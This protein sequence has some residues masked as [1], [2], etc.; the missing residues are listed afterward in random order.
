MEKRNYLN[1]KERLYVLIL[2]I[3][4]LYFLSG[5]FIGGWL[6]GGGGKDLWLI[7]STG[8]LAF[9][10]FSAPFF[11]KPSDSLATSLS[12]ILLLWSLDLSS[13]N[14]FSLQ[15]NIFRWF[16]IGVNLIIL[17]SSSIAII[18]K[19]R[20]NERS[21]LNKTCYLLSTNLGKGE[22]IFTSP[23][24][25]SILGFHQNKLID[26]LILGFIWILLV[27]IKPVELFFKIK[28][29]VREI[30][31]DST[32]IVGKIQRIDSPNIIRASIDSIDNWNVEDVNIAMLTDAKNV[33]VIPLF[34]Q[35]IDQ[36]IIGTGLCLE[37][38]TEL[39]NKLNKFC[40]YNSNR[41][42]NRSKLIRD[43][44]NIEIEAELIG[45]IVENSNISHI[46]FEISC[47]KNLKEG[48]I[49]FCKQDGENI[50]YQILDVYTTEEKFSSNPRGT[51]II[52]ATQLGEIDSEKGF[53]KY[54]WVPNMNTPVFLTSEDIKDSKENE[55]ELILGK[56]PNSNIDVVAD[57]DY[58]LEY[59]TAILGV[60][61]TG[62]TEMAFDIIKY[63]L[64]NGKKIF[65][66]DFTGDYKARLEEYNPVELSLGEE[67]SKKIEELI[68]KIE[69]GK[70]G[71]EDEKK[72]FKEFID[73]ITP[74]IKKKV[75]NF[76]EDDG[77]GLGIFELPN[78]A[79]SRAMLRATELYLSEIF[80]WARRNRKAREILVVL[81][82][83]HT[84]IPET[85]VFGYDKADTNLIINKI[86]QI[87][88]QG[89][90]YGVGLL[91]ISQ[92]T[93]LV[94]K[95]ILSQCNTYL[96]FSLVDQT[97]LKY[98]SS[99]YSSEH[100]DLIPNL[101]FLHT[102]VYGKGIKSE[103]SI[104]VEIPFDEQKQKETE[105]LND[106]IDNKDDSQVN[107]NEEVAATEEELDV[108]F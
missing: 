105:K 31:S 32:E 48:L 84:V 104:V 56:L 20:H 13:V 65:C 19:K 52:T 14:S 64:E 78:I 50:Y 92:R 75:K 46:K 74:E 10:L 49:V 60:T 69:T 1:I 30:K 45:F 40:V 12:V 72:K 101:Q 34:T 61:G 85:N 81:E 16:S 107:F 4:F 36:D 102:L 33:Y 62:K 96:T 9:R 3:V 79:T 83:A 100:I 21:S 25:I 99:V 70:Y 41:E 71:A 7:S 54:P 38:E 95:T 55:E 91:I 43:N 106:N 63:G 23:V 26:I 93:A 53:I 17:I 18:M 37:M 2:Y 24:L 27:V 67:D 86:S 15:I 58:L 28:N 39:D 90:K 98:L 22:L 68:F 29:K 35:I 80:S 82:E 57:F 5:F 11:S 47:N 44:M 97:S 103:R 77:A 87:A 66:V 51:H 76:L 94:S 88:L 59:H 8:Y 42:F 73:T 108:P 89:R 6:P